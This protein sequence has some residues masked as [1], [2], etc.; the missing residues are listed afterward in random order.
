MCHTDRDDMLLPRAIRIVLFWDNEY[1]SLS[2]THC[3]ERGAY[4]LSPDLLNNKAFPLT[5]ALSA[6]FPDGTTPE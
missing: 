1:T 3:M 4:S 2:T 6:G 5:R